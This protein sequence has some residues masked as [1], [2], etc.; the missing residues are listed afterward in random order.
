MKA[1]CAHVIVANRDDEAARQSARNDEIFKT[2][3]NRMAT[4]AGLTRW[5]I[6][7]KRNVGVDSGCKV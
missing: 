6:I 2:R 7:N 3:E 4:Q 5:R 1:R